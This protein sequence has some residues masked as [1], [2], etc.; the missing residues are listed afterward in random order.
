MVE[1]LKTA[2]HLLKHQLPAGDIDVVLER[3]LDE[4]ID[5]LKKNRFAAGS[6]KPRAEKTGTSKPQPKRPATERSRHVSAAD[7]REVF[8]R[9][10]LRCTFVDGRGRR[11]E[12]RGGLEFAHIEPDARGGAAVA[13]NLRLR[14][15]AHNRLDADRD[16][17]RGKMNRVIEQA[18]QRR[19]RPEPALALAVERVVDPRQV[20]MF[21]PE[22]G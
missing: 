21:S 2:Q 3:A 14:C 20:E 16:F 15:K 17:G 18:R 9:D 13:S 10:G 1:K 19:K 12:E 22:S 11:C 4:L 6:T 8:E 5:K 7:K